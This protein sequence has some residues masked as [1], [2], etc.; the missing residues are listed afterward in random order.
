[1]IFQE[2]ESS[3]SIFED[4]SQDLVHFLCNCMIDRPSASNE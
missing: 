2:E 1:V 3:V 4:L